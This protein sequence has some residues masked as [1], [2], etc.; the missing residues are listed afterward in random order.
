MK[1][2]YMGVGGSKPR[3]PRKTWLEMIENETKGRFKF[4]GLMNII[5]CINNRDNTLPL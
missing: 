1:F 3:R 2:L 5:Q 4:N